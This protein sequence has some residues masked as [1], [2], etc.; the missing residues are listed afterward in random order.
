MYRRIIGEYLLIASPPSLNGV[1]LEEFLYKCASEKER[2]KRK[3][4]SAD[5]SA[6]WEQ[7]HFSS[8]QELRCLVVCSPQRLCLSESII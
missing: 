7:A 1:S 4:W 6:K 8:D 2:K 5:K 3:W